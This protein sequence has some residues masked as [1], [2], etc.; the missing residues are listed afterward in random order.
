MNEVVPLLK[1]T[2]SALDPKILEEITVQRE[3]LIA[4]LVE[5]A[6][7]IES[8]LRHHLLVGPRGI[9]KTHVLSLV[10]T[11]L[12]KVDPDCGFAVVAWLHEDPW[13][14]RGYNKFLAA[15]IARVAETTC[16]DDLA[17]SATALRSNGAATDGLEGEALLR[18]AVGDRRLVL[19]VENLDEVFRRIGPDGQSRFRAFAEDW[20]QLLI[21]ASTPQLFAGVQRHASPFYGF[22]AV[23]HLD[24][25]SLTSATE[26][27]KRIANLHGDEALVRYLDTDTA[28]HRLTAVE[29]LAGGHPRIWLLLAGC[30]SI[31]GIDELVPLFL[32]ALDD[33]TP[34]YQ[35]RLHELSD[36][37]QELVVL[38]GEAGGALSNRELTERSGISQAQVAKLL[39]QLA[40][41]GY[42]RHATLPGH[43]AG[44]DRRMTFWELRE[45]LMRLCLDVKQAR[46]EPLRL[47]VEFLRAWYGPKLLDE[48]D[49]L[50][51]SATLAILYATEAFRTL[52]HPF[53][54]L[55]QNSP[56]EI[57]NLT[58]RALS[59][60]P[61]DPQLLYARASAL[62]LLGR[63]AESRDCLAQGLEVETNHLKAA[64]MRYMLA[65]NRHK[66]GEEIDP[67]ALVAD[68]I[69]I[70]RF[71]PFTLGNDFIEAYAYHLAGRHE[72][73]LA[74]STRAAKFDPEYA[75]LHRLRSTLLDLAQRFDKIEQAL[76]RAAEL[77]DQDVDSR[78]L[79]A[80]MALDRGDPTGGLAL[81]RE[82]LVAWSIERTV[83]PGDTGHLC[84]T[85]MSQDQHEAR[86]ETIAQVVATFAEFDAVDELGRGLTKSILQI[87][88]QRVNQQEAD[89]WVEDWESASTSPELEI[90]L[91]ML[92]AA[93]E[94]KRDGDRAHLLAL[95]PEQRDILVGL[96]PLVDPAPQPLPAVNMPGSK[97][98]TA[99]SA[100]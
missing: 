52:E 74:T 57:L 10:A 85:L 100:A 42:V 82:A 90:P 7:D 79:L 17:R 69:E 14:I 23:T 71:L 83:P 1:F 4:T 97:D 9:G 40:D 99:G 81:L 5:S 11:R 60:R 84:F 29:A 24:E 41:R 89:A 39:S 25:L 32:E 44:G 61:Q 15:I 54:D 51:A 12:R 98:F 37:Q 76:R 43:L 70:G 22:F 68:A 6:L 88:E 48:L 27:L 36:Q 53:D 62:S 67:D 75:A 56:E 13:A 95:P 63:L 45:P 21:L 58:E 93:C 8:G 16:D 87:A 94:W 46:G 35:D 33:L 65:V 28:A 31:S 19:L 38:L 96:L 92:K 3:P 26:L 55:Q 86:R 2:P 47:V 78:F 30:I 72:D 59:I 73:V 34:Y 64:V 18:N 20:Q 49:R 66:L 91:R 80:M 50:P 77:D